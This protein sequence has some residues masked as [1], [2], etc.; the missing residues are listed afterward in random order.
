M[1]A[2]RITRN[3]PIPLDTMM[4][5]LTPSNDPSIDE[6]ALIPPQTLPTNA[7]ISWRCCDMTILRACSIVNV[8]AS[9]SN[10]GRRDA[11]RIHKLSVGA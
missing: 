8:V 7:S 1:I 2:N 6:R 11:A 10:T 9:V 4:S 3:P 5:G